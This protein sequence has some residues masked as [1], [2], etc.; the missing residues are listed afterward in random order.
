M[1][2]VYDYVVLDIDGTLYSH[3]KY[4]EACRSAGARLRS[5]AAEAGIP[6]S[7]VSGLMVPIRRGRVT[8]AVNLL[9]TRYNKQRM[10]V[11]NTIYDLDPS[12]FGIAR[13]IRLI[14]EIGSLRKMARIALFTNSPAI[15]AGRVVS[16]LGIRPLVE[17]E[18]MITL[19]RMDGGRIFKPARGAFSLLLRLL[20]TT[21]SRVVFLDDSKDNVEEARRMGMRAIQICNDGRCHLDGHSASRTIYEELSDLSSGRF[22]F[23]GVAR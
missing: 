7:F 4:V 8:Y 13:S 14:N 6:K 3:R 19:D 10:H 2:R 23:S 21:P 17:K 1:D 15:W 16:K 5:Y 18:K 11:M 22:R 20:R 9:C 12:R